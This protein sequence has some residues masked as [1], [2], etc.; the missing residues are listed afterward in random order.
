MLQSIKHLY[1]HD[2]VASDGEI[3]Q[4][5][6]FYFDEND[7]T[8][9]YLVADADSWLPGRQVLIS[10]HSLGRRDSAGKILHVNLTRKQIEKSP[11]I[12]PYKPVSR[13]YEEEFYQYYGWPSYWHGGGL[14]GMID[15]PDSELRENPASLSKSAAANGTQSGPVDAH[16][17]ATRAAGSQIRG[18][19][20]WMRG[21]LC[22][23]MI[24]PRS[25]A[26]RQVVIK[27]G[28]RLSCK[29][30]GIPTDKVEQIAWD[31]STMYVS[32]IKKTT[33]PISTLCPA[34]VGATD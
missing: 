13:K 27:T 8:I 20:D 10:P 15:F 7:W 24:D 3:G 18:G 12:E 23:Y 26:I 33:E 19:T 9:R 17:R 5:K 6:D 1:G 31:K 34:A 30:I 16:L 14:W 4:V 32:L 28:R 29:E 11:S 21:D 2:L 22:D 25:W